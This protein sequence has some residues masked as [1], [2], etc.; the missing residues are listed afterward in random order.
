MLVT[1]IIT[2]YFHGSGLI[3]TRVPAELV[4][5]LVGPN[6]FKSW[7]IGDRKRGTFHHHEL[8]SLKLA[9]STTHRLP[10]R[11]NA[12]CDLVVRQRRGDRRPWAAYFFVVGRRPQGGK[13]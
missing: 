9:Q 5:I 12:F 1:G 10:T 3:A 2:T 6:R 13:Q 8:P 11:A 4:P 7:A